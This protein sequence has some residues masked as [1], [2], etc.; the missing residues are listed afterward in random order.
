[1]LFVFIGQVISITHPA[2]AEFGA[3]QEGQEGDQEGNQPDEEVPIFNAEQM[4]R[5]NEAFSDQ[6]IKPGDLSSTSLDEVTNDITDIAND[7]TEALIDVYREAY[8]C[9]HNP[10]IV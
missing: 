5:L 7:I 6:G 3:Q 4:S 10:T 9:K 8:P 1:M 2:L